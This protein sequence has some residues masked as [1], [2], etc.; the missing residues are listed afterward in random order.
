MLF[1]HTTKTIHWTLNPTS[2][3][4]HTMRHLP[5]APT[6]HIKPNG[7]I[8]AASSVLWQNSGQVSSQ[9]DISHPSI[10]TKWKTHIRL[11][12]WS[13]PTSAAV[14]IFNINKRPNMLGIWHHVSWLFMIFRG[15]PQTKGTDT[16]VEAQCKQE[17]VSCGVRKCTEPPNSPLHKSL[18]AQFQCKTGL[19]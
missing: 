16:S 4:P 13:D 11:K 15:D 18:G 1:V 17:R 8:R 7:E 10:H 2:E 9:G 12:M 3:I 19:L 6:S 14:I 5:H